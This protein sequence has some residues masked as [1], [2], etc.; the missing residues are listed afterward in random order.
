MKNFF[1]GSFVTLVILTLGV[2]LYLRFGLAEVRADLPPS[3]L[4]E[5]VMNGAVHASVRRHAPEMVSPV[6]PTEE[7]LIVGGKLYLGGCSGCHGSPLNLKEDSGDSLFPPIPQLAKVHTEYTEA[8]IF[9]VTKH[10]I[11]RSGMF[12]NGKFSSDQDLWTIAMFIKRMGD[13]PPRVVDALK[14]KSK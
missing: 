4:E 2:F 14:E 12:A 6:A 1:L 8:Q 3:K 9:W 10:G 5:Y 13:L 11:R 7:N